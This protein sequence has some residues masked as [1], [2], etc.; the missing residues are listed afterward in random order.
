MSKHL[1]IGDYFGSVQGRGGSAG[2]TLTELSHRQARKLPRHSHE[3]CFLTLVLRGDYREQFLRDQRPVE[4]RPFTVGFH[5]PG[6][7]HQDEIGGSG[8]DLFMIEVDRGFSERHA[9]FLP[10]AAPAPD[11]FGSRMTWLATRLYAAFKQGLDSTLD[12]ES[13]TL[14][15]LAE[16][17]HLS[18]PNETGEPPWLRRA[19]ELLRARFTEPL[20]VAEVAAEVGVH[21]VHLS[22]TFRNRYRQTMGTAL[23]QLRIQDAARKLQNG[24]GKNLTEVALAVGFFDQA[25]FC[26]VFKQHTGVTPGEFRSMLVA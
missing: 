25:H 12:T 2:V 11:L 14:E 22:R 24:E 20:T 18:A 23:N 15:M 13:F 6:L 16:A 10:A 26:R 7:A 3:A 5:P 19:L 17:A 21:P 4:Y 8:A 1:Q 9:Q